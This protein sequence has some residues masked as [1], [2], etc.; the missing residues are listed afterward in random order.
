MK[1]VIEGFDGSGKTTIA[2]LLGRSLNAQVVHF[3]NDGAMTGPLIRS[4]LRREWEIGTL[5]DRPWWSEPANP[6]A[7]AFQALQIVNRLETFE[8]LDPERPIV[9]ARHW[10]SAWVY[11]QIDGLDGD[12]LRD[13]HRSMAVDLNILLDLDVDTSMARRAARDGALPP[14]R[15]EG[16]VET[17]TRAI[18]L[19]RRL[20]GEPLHRAGHGGGWHSVDA[21]NDVATVLADVIR[22]WGV[23]T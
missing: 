4:Y 21:T 5:T 14:E 10:Q 1:I 13:V 19:Y 11:G 6:S 8:T 23:A 18:D 9:F 7:L 16:T 22:L 12:W 15:Y 3:P 2:R 20:W 17:A